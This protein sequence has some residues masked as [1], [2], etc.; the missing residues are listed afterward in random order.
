MSREALDEWREH[1]LLSPT[2]HET[3]RLSI[4]SSPKD[5]A[6]LRAYHTELLS[7]PFADRVQWL[8]TIAEIRAF[9]PHVTGSLPHAK[10]V[11][12][13]EGG[14]VF[15]REAMTRVGDAARALGVRFV[16]G[17]SGTAS[18]LLYNDDG[19]GRI[20]G[21]ECVDGT[22]YR[23]GR[24]VLAAGAWS[25][26]LVDMEGQLVAKCW[27]LAHVRVDDP[28]E[29]LQL[30]N[31]PVVMDLEK[32]FLKSLLWFHIQFEVMHAR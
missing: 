22:V 28:E 27:T 20:V 4:A 23:A 18:R 3:G 1:P 15:A 2:F 29:R 19:D 10:A 30:Q 25:D 16:S 14:W 31:T 7:S 21:V 11:F 32:V 17:P 6:E 12:N 13:P 5:Y 24:L 9:A 26:T 8:D